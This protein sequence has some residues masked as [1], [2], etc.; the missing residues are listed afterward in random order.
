MSTVMNQATH[1]HR[2][3]HLLCMDFEKKTNSRA[4]ME[5]LLNVQ[6]TVV[7]TSEVRS[8]CE[9]QKSDYDALCWRGKSE[10][11]TWNTE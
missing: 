8:L 2:L 4:L 5:E 11:C 3:S 1:G 9:E 7:E 10:G 6:G